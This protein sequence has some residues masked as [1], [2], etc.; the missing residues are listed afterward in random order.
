MVALLTAGGLSL[1]FTLFLTPVFIK[2]FHKLQWG[3]FI[4][5]DGPQTHHSKRGTATMGGIVVIL[6]AVLAYFVATW[7]SDAMGTPT[8]VM[9]VTP[10][11]VRAGLVARGTEEWEA[12]HFAEMYDLFRAG[13]SEFVTDTV[14][15]VTGRP[16]RTGGVVP[17][18]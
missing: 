1:A 3:Q 10:A 12:D 15:Q 11:E 4:R 16:A 18:S 14:T 7:V 13:E 9:E 8:R 2:L 6:G 5:D 17:G